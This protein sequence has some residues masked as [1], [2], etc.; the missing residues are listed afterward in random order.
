[1]PS[2]LEKYRPKTLDGIIGQPKAIAALRRMIDAPGFDGGAFWISGPTGTGKST[3]ADAIAAIFASDFHTWRVK[4]RDC[5]ADMVRRIIEDAHYSS[6]DGRWKV[7]IVNE[8]QSMTEGAVDL[9]LDAL[10]PGGLPKNRLVIFT[11]AEREDA[12]LFGQFTRQILNRCQPVTFT[13][14]GV[15]KAAAEYVQGIAKVENLDGQPIEKYIRL[16][17][18][19]NN[20]IREMLQRVQR[21]VMLA[22]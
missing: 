12:D 18:D 10:D 4:G 22:S 8:S 21:G 19:C 15:A 9:W 17:G 2:L 7:Y 5:T 20:S 14:Q 3:L 6:I 13:N 11:T 1:M 16:A